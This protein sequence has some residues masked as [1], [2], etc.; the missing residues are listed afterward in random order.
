MIL[1]SALV[2]VYAISAFLNEK[3][4]LITVLFQ[5]SVIMRLSIV[6]HNAP[7]QAGPKGVLPWP[8]LLHGS[9]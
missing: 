2:F 7:P 9:P 3:P 5:V 1:F 4:R 8:Y 6:L